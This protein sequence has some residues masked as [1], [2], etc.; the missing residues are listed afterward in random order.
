MKGMGKMDAFLLFLQILLI[1]LVLSGDNAVVIAMACRRLPER[2]KKKAI[3]LGTAA[4]IVMRI[5][6]AAGAVYVL[7]VPYVQAIGAFFLFYIAFKLI[8][9][10]AEVRSIR[11]APSLGMAVRTMIAADFIM[12]LDNVLAVAA[13]AKGN[14]LLLACGIALSI[15]LIMWGSSLIVQWLNKVPALVYAGAGLLGYTSGEMLLGDAKLSGWFSTLH[16]SIEWVL[17]IACALAVVAGGWI[18]QRLA[19]KD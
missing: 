18:G 14:L 17:P 12:S 11:E 5:A 16:A 10:E 15:P 7:D 13:I 9:D 1:N 19:D 3:W 8:G 6:L 4:A 2:Q